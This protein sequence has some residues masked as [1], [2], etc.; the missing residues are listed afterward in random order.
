[1]SWRSCLPPSGVR[2]GG[3]RKEPM[4]IYSELNRVM[5]TGRHIIGLR[6]D[7]VSDSHFQSAMIFASCFLLGGLLL[8]S[9]CTP[10]HAY[11]DKQI[12]NAIYKAE[13]G[14]KAQYPYGIRSVSCDSKR[15]CARICLR[16]VQNNR[17]RYEKSSKDRTF[18]EFFASRYCPVQALD[19]HRKV[20]QYWLKNVLY[21]LKNENI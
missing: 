9:S 1:M 15:E 8:I 21:F 19:D 5:K 6:Q 10:A 18:L 12:V 14:A 17:L 4:K 3:Q 7:N 20:N 13:G 11:T 16:T 2:A